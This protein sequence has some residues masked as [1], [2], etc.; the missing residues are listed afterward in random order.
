[1]I[2]KV[3]SVVLLSLVSVYS[4]SAEVVFDCDK[5]VSLQEDSAG[6]YVSICGEFTENTDDLFFELV[7]NNKDKNLQRVAL[8]SYGGLVDSATKIGLFVEE[9]SWV[10]HLPKGSKCYSACTLVALA[11]RTLIG[12]ETVLGFHRPYVPGVPDTKESIMKAYHSLLPY[13]KKIEGGDSVDLYNKMMSTPREELY[14]VY[15]PGN[16]VSVL[17]LVKDEDGMW[18]NP[19]KN[20]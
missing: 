12:P 3:L 16:A 18:N 13:W 19:E 6:V 20:T 17:K 9:E 10:S 5:N 4:Y 1:M 14:N 7:D 15:S 2:N 8:N 11:G